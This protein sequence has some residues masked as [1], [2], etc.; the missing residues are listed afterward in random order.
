MS[1][2]CHGFLISF[3]L[4]VAGQDAPWLPRVDIEDYECRRFLPSPVVN[5]GDL[6]Q[7]FGDV[8]KILDERT[9]RPRTLTPDAM[10]KFQSAQVELLEFAAVILWRF[11]VALNECPF[12]AVTASLFATLMAFLE[13]NE[14]SKGPLKSP[15]DRFLTDLRQQS[16]LELVSRDLA[17]LLDLAPLHVTAA[18]EWV[19]F[20][21]LHIYLPKI[22]AEIYQT[23]PPESLTCAGVSVSGYKSERILDMLR[24]HIPYASGRDIEGL[25]FL[26]GLDPVVSATMTL[27]CIRLVTQL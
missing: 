23:V 7:R 27:G 16:F 21:L 9:L 6:R 26:R 3:I 5:W 22:R 10:M 1:R 4:S 14:L 15:Y 18:S 19:S 24:R 17:V 13:K 2:V 11:P 12:G 20:H 25:K 8:V